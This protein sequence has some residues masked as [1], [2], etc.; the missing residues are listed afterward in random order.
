MGS[1]CS[2][3]RSAGPVPQC[4][5]YIDGMAYHRDGTIVKRTTEEELIAQAQRMVDDDEGNK[6][7]GKCGWCRRRFKGD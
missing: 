7:E 1:L 4:P 6:R 2:R 3:Y 5:K